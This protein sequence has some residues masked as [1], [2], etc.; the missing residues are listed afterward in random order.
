MAALDPD[1]VAE[2]RRLAAEGVTA[3][4]IAKTLGCSPATVHKYAPAGSFNRSTTAA[5]VHAHQLDAAARR[6][7]IRLKLLIV[8]ES[9]AERAVTTYSR[10]EPTGAEGDLTT[11]TT[12]LPPA[13]ETKDLVQAAVAASAQELKIAEY[14]DREDY[15][16]ATDTI[17]GFGREIRAQ[18]AA[19]D[20]Q[21]AG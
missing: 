17:L 10:T 8:A 21:Q 2:I 6:E 13:R 14:K 9:A 16:D 1:K 19:E 5:A 3:Y 15:S 18:I 11:W 4:R 7:R 12:K 20:A